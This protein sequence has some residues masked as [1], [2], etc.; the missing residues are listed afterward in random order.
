[1]SKRNDPSAG[2]QRVPRKEGGRKAKLDL[3]T[4]YLTLLPPMEEGFTTGYQSRPGIVSDTNQ[5]PGQWL[6]NVAKY[7]Q[8]QGEDVG[9]SIP[10]VLAGEQQMRRLMRLPQEEALRHQEMLNWRAVLA[11]LLLWDGWTKDDTWPVL[12]YEDYLTPESMAGAMLFQRTVATALTQERISDGLKIFALSKLSDQRP[13]KRPLCMVSRSVIVMPAAN[14]GDL[15]QL[16]PAQI[17]WY[18][19][20]RGRW[21]DPW[22]FLNESDRS[23]LVMQLR[24]LQSM[25]EQAEL[26]SH[27]YS[28]TAELC[29]PL[30]RFIEDLQGFRSAWREKLMKRE[31]SAVRD[32]YTRTLT[33]Y[34]LCGGEGGMYLQG[35]AEQRQQ[36]DVSLLGKNPLISVL[37]RPEARLPESIANV[38]Q[39][40]Y[41][42]EGVPFARASANYLL[43]PTNTPGEEAVVRRLAGEVSLLCEYSADWNRLLANRLGLLHSQM[44][45]RVGVCPVVLELLKEWQER[46]AAYPA[47]RDRSISLY[48][49]IEGHPQA[50]GMLMKDLLGLDDVQGICGAFSDCLL[51][52][53]GS[54]RQPFDNPE[55]A[56]MCRVRGDMEEGQPRYAVP[57]LS[58]WLAAWLMDQ[59]E[60]GDPYAPRLLPESICVTKERAT[61]DVSVAFRI[62]CKRQGKDALL[63]NSVTF[64]RT[65]SL[66]QKGVGSVMELPASELPFVV[67]WPNLRMTPGLWKQYFVYTH[68]P[69]AVDVWVRQTVGWAQGTLR[70]TTDTNSQGQQRVRIWQTAVTERYPAYIVLRRGPM[71]LGALVNDTPRE[72]LKH[73]PPAVIGVDFGSIATTVMLRQGDK[74]QPATLPRCLHAAL[75]HGRDEDAAL[76]VDEFLPLNA[77]L[78]TPGALNQRESTFYSVMDMFTDQQDRWLS[79]LRD[80]HIYFQESIQAL[81][82]KNENAIYY[83]MKW[84]EEQFALHC[85]RLYL[86]QVMVQA[87]LASR[88]CGA[89]SLS[90]RVSMPNALPLPRQESYLEMMRALSA[91]V[92][93]ETG[94]PLTPELPSV[95]YATENQADGLYFKGRNEVNVRSGYINMDIGGGTTDISLWLGGAWRATLETSLLMGCRQILF[96]S[97]TTRHLMEFSTDFEQCDEQVKTV[98]RGLVEALTH[99]AGST[100][101]RQKSMFL[102][103]DFFA[104]YDQQIWQMMERA[105]SQGRISYVESLLLVNIGFLFHLCGELLNRG[106]RN[107][108]TRPLLHERMEVCIAGNGGQLLKAFDNESR[109]K[110]CRLALQGLERGNVVREL[111]LVQSR[112]P[113]QEVAIGL[114]S[115]EQRMRSTVHGEAVWAPGEE[116]TSH[117]QH[118]SVLHSFPVRFYHAFPQ[119]ADRLMP[120][121]FERQSKD[122][123]GLSASAKVELDTILDN[124]FFEPHEDEFVAYIRCFAAMKRLWRV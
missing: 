25:N 123:V 27:L 111:V 23:R 35:L 118:Q 57:P 66:R 88:L 32:L 12:T 56:E 78:P 7:M 53:T 98:V 113:K 46:H 22:P 76:L 62:A 120:G 104:A 33:V 115:E 11:L 37:M 89:P 91:E 17:R 107:P 20:Q 58:P 34:G 68:Y 109:A 47:Q 119:A 83:D 79:I 8:T 112:H 93:A 92:A 72:Q 51:L 114:L 29:S 108:E 73:E 9:Y 61:G 3:Q 39:T 82:E 48:Y 38:T 5:K 15:G 26:G 77:L 64:C 24:L 49:P 116:P 87:A 95:L 19:R 6:E 103:D 110:L 2:I 44:K 18:D 1:M 45:A 84:G 41:L 60:S 80:G 124:E 70:Q 13:D 94:M 30:E 100:R 67:S 99:G 102:L 90:W 21:M 65:Y 81:L 96:D 117:A 42:L 69:E 105:R 59:A 50:L 101:G 86:K 97:V 16:L 63:T 55:L 106:W 43:E 122:T 4:T 74:V 31:E 14:P 36:L 85:V 40:Q 121:V 75:L 28:E 10:D 54:E 71:S 52:I